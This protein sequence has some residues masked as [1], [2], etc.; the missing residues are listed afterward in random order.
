[1]RM[2]ALE[3]TLKE[4]HQPG[5]KRFIVEGYPQFRSLTWITYGPVLAVIAVIIL[6]GLA[7]SMDIRT[8]PSATKM[9]F[10][11]LM[12]LVPLLLWAVGAGLINLL[13]SRALQQERIATSRRVEINLDLAEK[14]LRLNEGQPINFEAISNFKLMTSNG[15]YYEPQEEISPLVQLMMDTNQGQQMILSKELGST[16]QKLQ[17]ASQLQALITHNQSEI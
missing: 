15:V 7:W 13:V 12:V 5:L 14:T 10:V 1:M 8:Q 9:T 2:P 3:T 17:L 16:P 6:G 4:D 11:C